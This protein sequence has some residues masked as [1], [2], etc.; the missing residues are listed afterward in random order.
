MKDI[1]KLIPLNTT[2]TNKDLEEIFEDE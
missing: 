2:I 1:L